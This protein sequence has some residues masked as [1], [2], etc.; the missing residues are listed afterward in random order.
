MTPACVICAAMMLPH[1]SVPCQPQWSCAHSPATVGVF[2]P[3]G[4]QNLKE[5]SLCL[6][7]LSSSMAGASKGRPDNYFYQPARNSSLC[8]LGNLCAFQRP[9]SHLD[10]SKAVWDMITMVHRFLIKNVVSLNSQCLWY[11]RRNCTYL[12]WGYRG[13]GMP[14]YIEIRG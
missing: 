10:L 12:V 6:W 4:G 11:L 1:L 3:A 9:F 5:D 13:G 14:R 7:H 8:L 2:F